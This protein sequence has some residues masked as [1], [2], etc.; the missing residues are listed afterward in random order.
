MA[1]KF[2]T[3]KI[4]R[5]EFKEYLSTAN[6]SAKLILA[7]MER[8]VE[9]VQS[10]KMVSAVQVTGEKR[11]VVLRS[12]MEDIIRSLYPKLKDKKIEISIDIDEKLVLNSFPGAWSQ[13]LTNLLLNS[14]VH[15]FEGRDDGIIS[16]K[17]KKDK[18]LI[19]IEYS[20]NG[21][22]I[23]QENVPRIFDP[24]F[25][26]NKK[27]GTGLGLHIVFNTVTLKLGG[28]IRCES[29]IGRGTTFFITLPMAIFEEIVGEKED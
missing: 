2:K 3:N 10:F 19:V 14:L 12:Y 23:P 24:F 26:T 11:R 20:D 9:M 6:Q 13:V 18:Q 16:L 22:G 7:N 17:A 29:R 15:G 21:R 27:A 5:A 1:E 25:T 8:T 4:S 28:S